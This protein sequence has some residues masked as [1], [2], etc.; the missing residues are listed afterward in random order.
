MITLAT[1][2]K[3]KL[4]TPGEELIVET[5]TKKKDSGIDNKH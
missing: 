2:M 5:K 1:L 3:R 4:D